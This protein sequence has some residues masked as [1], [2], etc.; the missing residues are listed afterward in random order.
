MKKLLVIAALIISGCGYESDVEKTSVPQPTVTN[1]VVVTKE[2]VVTNTVCLTN[3]VVVRQAPARLLSMR[4]SAPYLVSA[5]SLQQDQLRNL[6]SNAGARMVECNAGSIALVE[7]TDKTVAMLKAGGVLNVHQLLP[8]D[9]IAKDA[10]GNVRVIPLSTIDCAAIVKEIRQQ[11]GEIL[12]V[13]TVG[14]PA[15]RAKMT[16]SAIKKLAERGDVR[17]IERDGK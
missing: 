4:R 13:V 9:K 2:L 12:Q 5:P 6:L 14:K 16:F 15:I 10:G 11:G 3:T 17:R 8:E 7:A 1:F